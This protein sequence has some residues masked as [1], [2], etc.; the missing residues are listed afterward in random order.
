MNTRDTKPSDHSIQDSLSRLT[1]RNTTRQAKAL[2][3][4]MAAL[5]IGLSTSLTKTN[6]DNRSKAAFFKSTYC[7]SD[8]CAQGFSCTEFD[9]GSC[10]ITEPEL[11]NSNEEV[12]SI[13][14]KIDA[15]LVGCNDGRA[16]AIT[17]KNCSERARTVLQGLQFELEQIEAIVG[18]QV[19][20]TNDLYQNIKDCLANNS[21]S[22]KGEA[23]LIA[24][25]IDSV[26]DKCLQ[27]SSP[28]CRELTE[29]ITSPTQTNKNSRG[30]KLHPVER[31]E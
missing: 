2:I 30:F 21:C 28:I 12:A 1:K 11:M 16:N 22:S 15:T 17:S 24:N 27:A 29:T 19:D 31:G 25:Q 9:G 14:D 8:P 5:S 4:T 26:L 13:L 23:Q 6:T 3:V 7:S 20:A 18:F 10:F